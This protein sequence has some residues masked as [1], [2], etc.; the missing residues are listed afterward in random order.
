M[1]NIRDLNP[2]YITDSKGEKI[3]VILSIDDFQELLEELEDL[4][5]IAERI[6]DPLIPHEKVK[7]ELKKSG[8]L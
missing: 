7:E 5:A 6:D 8:L 4:T 2:Q 3:S 1:L